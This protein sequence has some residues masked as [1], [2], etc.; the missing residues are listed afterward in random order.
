M[1]ARSPDAD[2]AKDR[3]QLFSSPSGMHRGRRP[4]RSR[5]AGPPAGAQPCARMS[6][7]G[8]S[9]SSRTATA[10]DRHENARRVHA[11]QV[12][13]FGQTKKRFGPVARRVVR[14]AREQ[15]VLDREARSVSSSR[16]AAPVE[17]RGELFGAAIGRH[18]E[19]TREL[20]AFLR[21]LPHSIANRTMRRCTLRHAVAIGC[22]R[23]AA[24]ITISATRAPDSARRRRAPP[25][26]R[27]SRRRWRAAN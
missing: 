16:R 27:R 20:Q 3:A 13:G 12:D 9:W 22:A 15:V 1:P 21:P 4:R 8:T 26:R 10:V 2:V 17:S 11:M 19:R 7:S 18:R 25:C 23:S 6:A 14:A 24:P 5:A